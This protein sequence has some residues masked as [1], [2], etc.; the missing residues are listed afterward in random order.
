M[1]PHAVDLCPVGERSLLGTGDEVVK[2]VAEGTKADDV[3]D[4]AFASQQPGLV[5]HLVELEARDTYER[6]AQ[7]FL[8]RAWAFPDYHYLGRARARWHH[9][10]QLP[11]RK[12]TKMNSAMRRT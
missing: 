7:A 4:E 1:K 5:E 12:K 2:V 8:I 3:R 6:A 9:D 10:T 11:M